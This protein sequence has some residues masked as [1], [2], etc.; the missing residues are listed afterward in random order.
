[1]SNQRFNEVL[2]IRDYKKKI[3]KD[4][5]QSYEH[6][7]MEALGGINVLLEHF[8]SNARFLKADQVKKLHKIMKQAKKGP[9]YKNKKDNP[10]RSYTTRT[11]R[12][13]PV[14]QERKY[15]LLLEKHNKITRENLSLKHEIERKD[16]NCNRLTNKNL[17][18]TSKAN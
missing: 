7:I 10:Q 3:P 13:L 6:E 12:S 14:D 5:I 2:E 16:R 8:L 9:N 4:T 11:L 18:L 17:T 1:M 15:S